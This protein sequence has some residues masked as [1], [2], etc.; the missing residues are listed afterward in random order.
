VIFQKPIKRK[1][2][3]LARKKINYGRFFDIDNKSTEP[4]PIMK[5]AGICGI[6]QSG[7]LVITEEGFPTCSNIQCG[8]IYTNTLDYS[9]EW[10]FYGSDDRNAKDP[11]R[12]GNPINPLL[13]ESSYG[14]KVICSSKST[15]EMR[16]N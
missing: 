11:S 12:C 2:I 7:T 9:P 13:V 5:E 16:K 10:R 8:I 6:C 4:T 3:F 14:C 1:L 15:Y